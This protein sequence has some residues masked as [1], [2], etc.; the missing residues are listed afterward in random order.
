M[1]LFLCSRSR[2]RGATGTAK[3]P[4]K[5][6]SRGLPIKEKDKRAAK[7][8]WKGKTTTLRESNHV[9]SKDA[10]DM[11]TFDFQ[12]NLRTPNLHHSEVFFMR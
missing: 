6:G 12:Q 3:R 11:I 8:T 5:P 4:S 1:G 10:F 2:T 9:N 7:E